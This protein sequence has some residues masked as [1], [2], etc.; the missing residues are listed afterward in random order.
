MLHGSA[1]IQQER[2]QYLSSSLAHFGHILPHVA[3]CL[4]QHPTRILK[5]TNCSRLE[6]VSPFASVRN[7]RRDMGA[8]SKGAGAATGMPTRL[9]AQFFHTSMKARSSASRMQP[10]QQAVG[11]HAIVAHARRCVPAEL[12]KKKKYDLATRLALPSRL[13]CTGD[14]DAWRLKVTFTC[15]AGARDVPAVGQTSFSENVS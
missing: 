7:R 5:L 6:S 13:A 2:L 9:T 8:C 12:P 11:L 10:R 4:V 1:L 15:C 14:E 3:D